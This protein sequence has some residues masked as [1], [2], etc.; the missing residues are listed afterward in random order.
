M[1]EPA[2]HRENEIEIRNN[3]S[4]VKDLTSATQDFKG[5]DMGME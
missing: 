1:A 4:R 5:Q 3:D 2:Q